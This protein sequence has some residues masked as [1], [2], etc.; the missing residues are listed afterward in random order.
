MLKLCNVQS[1][2]LYVVHLCIFI[3]MSPAFVYCTLKALDF[4]YTHWQWPLTW[5]LAKTLIELGTLNWFF[6]MTFYSI[7]FLIIAFLWNWIIVFR[8]KTFTKSAQNIAYID[9]CSL[10]LSEWLSWSGLE[11]I[12]LINLFKNYKYI[13]CT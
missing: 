2:S 11:N 3:L 13:I 5:Q 6:F 1:T 4:M 7:Q 12:G 10:F 9:Q 8:V